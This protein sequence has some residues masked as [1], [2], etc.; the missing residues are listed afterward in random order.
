MTRSEVREGL[1]FK[2]ISRHVKSHKDDELHFADLTRPEQLNVLADHRATAALDTL[3]AAGMTTAFFPLPTCRG[4][5]RRYITS[6][7]IRTLR[8]ALP[9]NELREYL[10]CR[11]DWSNETYNSIRWSAYSS[12][13][14]GISDNA[15]TFVVKLTHKWLPIGLR[16]RRCSATSDL[17]R[18][19]N[20]VET[21]PHLYRC[22]SREAWRY[23]FLTNLHGHLIETKTAAGIRCI[24]TK[25]IWKDRCAAVH[26]PGE[27]SPD[28]SSVR[29]REA[30]QLRVEIACAHAPFMLAH[31]RR[32]LDVT[33][34]ERLQSRISELLA[35]VETM[36]PVINRYV[37]DAQAQ[38]RTGHRDIRDFFSRAPAVTTVHT[39][40]IPIDTSSARP[41]VPTLDTR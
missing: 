27:T 39:A 33:L 2:L 22:R 16:E 18:H 11:N 34:E 4:Y 7:E 25:G 1:P 36:L 24:I 14:A 28:N 40:T 41:I 21:V 10:Q 13:S 38:I 19:C 17:C 3:R 32:V 26:A 12:A 8:T 37:R 15:R 9:E 6:R 35:W 29:T 30:A 31:D 20:E 5:L 23:R